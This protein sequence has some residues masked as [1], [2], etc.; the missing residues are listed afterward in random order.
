MTPYVAVIYRCES[1]GC[2]TE[3]SGDI[4]INSGHYERVEVNCSNVYCN[5]RRAVL[6]TPPTVVWPTSVARM[7]MLEELTKPHNEDAC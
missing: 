4:D 7:P 1:C 3:I 6:F 2:S 5:Q